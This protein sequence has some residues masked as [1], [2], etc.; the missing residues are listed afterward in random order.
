MRSKMRVR[1]LV[2]SD[3]RTLHEAAY[4]EYQEQE[5]VQLNIENA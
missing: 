3:L 4:R 2:E 1:L 5:G